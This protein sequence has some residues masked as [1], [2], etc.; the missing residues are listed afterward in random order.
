VII[1]LIMRYGQFLSR[2]A[3]FA[4]PR[5]MKSAGEELTM[6][7]IARGTCDSGSPAT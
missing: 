7:E 2:F 1:S 5:R 4:P 6:R 3:Q